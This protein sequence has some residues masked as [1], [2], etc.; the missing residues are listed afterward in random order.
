MNDWNQL[1][2]RLASWTPRLPSAALKARLFSQVTETAAA[3]P[4]TGL[5]VEHFW[6]F[7]APG[8]ALLLAVCM[9]NT[10]GTSSFTPIITSPADLVATALSANPQLASYC[11]NAAYTEHNIW[12]NSRFEW[13]NRTQSR[14]LTTY[15]PLRMTNQ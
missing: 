13:T 11:A 2:K 12:P 5:A 15:L 1:E 7:L 6:R 3:A 4:A 9:V 10:R 14:S 8:L